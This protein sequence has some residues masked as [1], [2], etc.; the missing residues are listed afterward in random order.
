MQRICFLVVL[1]VLSSSAHAGSSLSFT[2]GGHRIRIEAPRHCTSPSCVSVSIPGIYRNSRWRDH[3]DDDDRVVA[4]P[5]KAPA[6]MQQAAPV[7]SVPPPANPAVVPAVAAPPTVFKPAA[8]ATQ[9][10]AAPPKPAIAPP[11]ALPPVPPPPPPAMTPPAEKPA[12]AVRPP[13]A[14]GPQLSSV[15]HQVEDEP[16]DTPVGDW[17]SAGNKGSVRIERCGQALCGYA[18]KLSSNEKG[19]AVLVNMKPKTGSQWS[20]NVYSHGSGDTYYGTMALKG[21]NTLRV[22]ACA[23]GR[24]YC[25]GNNWSRIDVNP[26]RLIS[27]RQN[28]SAP[29]S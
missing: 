5:V 11:P 28:A 22:E 18:L 27:S 14:A 20:G 26:K 21:P 4:D 13:A 25:S 29:R 9:Q 15:L 8:A 6:A 17:Q 1:T 24:F 7:H 2:V 16:A 3:D 12:E 10:V 23:L 19:E